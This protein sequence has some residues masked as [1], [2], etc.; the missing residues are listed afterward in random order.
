M[1]SKSATINKLK[2]DC[3]FSEWEEKLKEYPIKKQLL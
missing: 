2:I 1:K 3:D